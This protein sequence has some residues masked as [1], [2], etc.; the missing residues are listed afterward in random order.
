[1]LNRFVSSTVS[2]IMLIPP[3]RDF[4]ILLSFSGLLGIS[5]FVTAPGQRDG[6]FSSLYSS[7]FYLSAHKC[8]A[9]P[10][11]WKKKGFC[12]GAWKTAVPCPY[13]LPVEQNREKALLHNGSFR[14]CPV[15]QV[16]LH[17][18]QSGGLPFQSVCHAGRRYVTENPPAYA[19]FVFSA[20]PSKGF[21]RLPGRLAVLQNV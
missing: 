11:T 19:V 10:L 21:L 9:C 6:T 14:G 17:F 12:K 1:M 13:P 7:R 16:L 5:L 18:P 15:L 4:L 8:H 2:L 20:V 3:I